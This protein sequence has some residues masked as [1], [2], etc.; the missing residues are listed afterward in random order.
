MTCCL[1][2]RPP[3]IL[4]QVSATRIVAFSYMCVRLGV[5]AYGARMRT[6]ALGVVLARRCEIAQH[7]PTPHPPLALTPPNELLCAG[8]EWIRSVLIDSNKAY[9]GMNKCRD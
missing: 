2:E 6:V 3:G 8:V 1:V 5:A 7:T 4:K 9:S